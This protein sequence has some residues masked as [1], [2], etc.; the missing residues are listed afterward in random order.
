MSPSPLLPP[1]D[2]DQHRSAGIRSHSF[3]A[4]SVLG[5]RDLNTQPDRAAGTVSA[6]PCCDVSLVTAC[7][8][9]R[10]PGMGTLIVMFLVIYKLKELLFLFLHVWLVTQG[11]SLWHCLSHGTSVLHCASKRA[12]HN[13]APEVTVRVEFRL[14]LTCG[15]SLY[16]SLGLVTAWQ[17]HPPC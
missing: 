3:G 17:V 7:N 8:Q 4:R 11:V 10:L 2:G 6:H 13:R 15:I 1:Q 5:V 9:A 12:V 16:V 14:R